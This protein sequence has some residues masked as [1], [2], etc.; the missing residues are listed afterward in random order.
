MKR[1]YV[2]GVCIFIL[3][4]ICSMFSTIYLYSVN[5]KL[6]EDR[7]RHIRNENA[8]REDLRSYIDANGNLSYKVK[9]VE[10]S[11]SNLKRSSDSSYAS[12]RKVIKDQGVK[13][14]ELKGIISV[15]TSVDTMFKPIYIDRKILV[16]T[17]LAFGTDSLGVDVCIDSNR[18]TSRMK[19]INHQYFLKTETRETVNPPYK[20]FLWRW[21]QRK[22]NVVTL[23][24]HNTNK[25]IKVNEAEYKI[26]TD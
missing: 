6:S 23:K 13:I 25:G 11:Y 3:I 2:Y 17:C 21:F 5:A 24:I 1:L 9:L 8:Y 4:S 16:D 12:Y 7:D 22:H 14:K 10:D 18:V 19:V 20:F 26:F 15:G